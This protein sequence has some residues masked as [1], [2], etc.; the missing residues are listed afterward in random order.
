MLKVAS[1]KV[2]K[3]SRGYDIGND[4]AGKQKAV[5]ED[6]IEGVGDYDKRMA[7]HGW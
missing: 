5:L 3:A 6:F 7:K 4:I 1:E 2:F